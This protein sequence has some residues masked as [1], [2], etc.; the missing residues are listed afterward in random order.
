M[1]IDRDALRAFVEEVGADLADTLPP[2]AGRVMAALLVSVSAEMSLEQLADLLR[3]SRGA[4]SMA[5][6]TLLRLGI[7][8]KVRRPPDRRSYF[9]LR[10]NL[11]SELYLESLEHYQTHVRNAE[12]GLALLAEEPLETKARLIEMSAFFRFIVR[13]L[14]EFIARWRE[15]GPQLIEDLCEEHR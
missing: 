6:Q 4:M 1:T 8:Q 13:G 3:A 12:Q 11:W 5:T 7:V 2:M 14:P 15:E 10:P 9:R